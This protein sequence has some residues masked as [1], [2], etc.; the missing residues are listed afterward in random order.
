MY[1]Y[2]NQNGGKESK[3]N[4]NLKPSNY[5]FKFQIYLNNSALPPPYSYVYLFSDFG[6]H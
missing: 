6:I 2:A 5:N 3:T 1:F 4:L